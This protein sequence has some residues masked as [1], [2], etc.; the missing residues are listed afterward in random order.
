MGSAGG[1]SAPLGLCVCSRA[2]G[3]PGQAASHA[4]LCS[5]H[6]VPGQAS[7]CVHVRASSGPQFCLCFSGSSRP[8]G[9]YPHFSQGRELC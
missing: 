9:R 8:E 1:A 4:V 2:C 6:R 7:T 5:G 3:L